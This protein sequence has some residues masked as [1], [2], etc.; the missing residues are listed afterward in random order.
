MSYRGKGVSSANDGSPESIHEGFA[1]HG[2]AEHRLTDSQT[3]PKRAGIDI[4]VRECLMAEF[5]LV[6]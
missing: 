3:R 2:R 5:Y 4:S 1:I 6:T